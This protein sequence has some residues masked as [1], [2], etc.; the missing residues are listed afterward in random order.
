MCNSASRLYDRPVLDFQTRE[1]DMS[2]ERNGDESRKRDKGGVGVSIVA[3]K[4]S[5]DAARLSTIGNHFSARFHREPSFFVRVPG[6]VNLIGEHID[7][8]GYAVCPMAIR[9]DVLVAVSSTEDGMLRLTNLEAKYSDFECD[10]GHIRTSSFDGSPAWQNY[11]LCGVKGALDEIPEGRQPNGMLAA[12]WGNVPPSSGLSSSSALVSAAVLGTMHLSECNRSKED[13]GTISA[14]AERY[15]GTQGGGMDQAIAFLGQEGCAKLIEFDPLRAFDVTL[16]RSAVFVIAHSLARHNKASTSDYNLRVAECR[17][18]AQIIAKRNGLKWDEVKKLVDVQAKLNKNLNEM[19]GIVEREL[20]QDSYSLEEI[21]S[22]LETTLEYLKK[23]SLTKSFKNSQAFKLRQRALHVF[24]EA[25]RVIEF[26]EINQRDG[27]SDKERLRH[28]GHL[29]TQSHVS[30]DQ[31]YECSHPELNRLVEDAMECGA[32]GA[33]LTGAGWG[34]CAVILTTKEKV[35]DFLESLKEKFYHRRG[36]KPSE[37]E[38]LLF[39][40]E[41]NQGA[42][43]YIP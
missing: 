19:A 41:P 5:R 39:P 16:P 20:D 6:R 7:Y 31:M 37:T 33:R 25:A 12:V 15:I 4:E 9:Q 42:A 28:L 38:G 11:F 21:C 32:L 2:K 14:R 24:Q 8:C 34:G 10:F 40:T 35:P 22:T 43:I 3:A 18:A 30:L 23:V 29:M 13:M 27:K 36:I 17:I 26:R 1:Q